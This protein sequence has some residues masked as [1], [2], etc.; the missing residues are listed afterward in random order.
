[1]PR[2][3]QLTSSRICLAPTPR[4]SFSIKLIPDFARELDFLRLLPRGADVDPNDPR[5]G[6]VLRL[7]GLLDTLGLGRRESSAAG[8]SAGG[9]VGLDLN[10][11]RR[12]EIGN[13]EGSGGAGAEDNEDQGVF[14]ASQEQQVLVFAGKRAAGAVAGL[15]GRGNNGGGGFHTFAYNN[16]RR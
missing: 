7:G 9:G 2:I 16:H 4:P 3:K 8:H 13:I 11:N 5:H 14:R 6:N 1:M 15:A 10:N 12:E